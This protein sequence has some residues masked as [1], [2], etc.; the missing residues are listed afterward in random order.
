MTKPYRWRLAL[1]L[2]LPLAG[3]A[4][5]PSGPQAPEPVKSVNMARLYTGRWY[6]IGREP[7]KLTDGCVAGTTTYLANAQ[8]K[9]VQRDACHTGTPEGKE[10]AF[11]G[12]V[13]VLNPGQNNKISVRYHVWGIFTLPY[14]YWI[15]DH[16]KDYGWFIVATPNMHIVSILSRNPDPPQSEINR[17][18]AKVRALGYDGPLEYPARFPPGGGS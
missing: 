3:C 15:L 18:T 5:A 12:T 4:A 7:T 13:A 17:L 11:Q 2:I 9:L 14:T 16:G 10:R 6:E 1:P 8:G